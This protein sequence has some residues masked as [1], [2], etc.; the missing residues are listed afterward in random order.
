VPAGTT[1]MLA[2]SGAI[3]LRYHNDPT[4]TAETFITHDGTRYAIPG[5]VACLEH[6]GSITVLGRRSSCIN[7][8]GEKVYPIE[9]ENVLKT[10]PAVDD[11]LVVG[12]A[13]ERWGQRV[14]VIVAARAG[15][16]ITLDDVQSHARPSWRAT[17]SAIVVPRRPHRAPAVGQGRPPVG[18]A[19]RRDRSSHR[20]LKVN[21]RCRTSTRRLAPRCA[22]PVRPS[23]A[24]RA[25]SGRAT[26]AGR[27]PRPGWRCGTG[28]APRSR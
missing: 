27:C 11:C 19:R 22:A 21:Q 5:D 4:K 28:R 8:G 9:V 10:L 3:P 7:T 2:K 14:C 25:G 15:Q 18:R 20:R 17:R 26:T 6:D 16:H 12:L 1:G 24:R 23:G 13:D